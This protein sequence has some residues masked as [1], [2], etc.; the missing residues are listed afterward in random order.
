MNPVT[1][2]I[3][4]SL[5]RIRTML[6]VLAVLL[7]VFQFLLTQI[8]SYLIRRDAFSEI[9]LLMPDFVRSLLGP[10]SLAFL[11][12]SGIVAFGYFHPMV[13]AAVVWLVITIASEPAGEVETRFVDLA[14]ARELRRGDFI[15]RTIV[16]L[17]FASGF[18]LGLMM[19]GTW[20]GLACCVPAN[21]PHASARL[22]VSLAISLGAVMVCWSGVALAVAAAARR[23]SVA[24][25]IVGIAA[26]TAFL[27]DYVGRAWDPARRVSMISPF[28]YFDP[29]ALVAGQPLSAANIGVLVAIGVVGM[30]VAAIVFSRRDI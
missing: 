5:R 10:S 4:H 26:L 20:T 7:S 8:A 23:R 14:L 15:A 1:A 6:I 30:I 29:T 11:S 18:V 16:V 19:L 12:F 21:A 28:H 3:A 9:A 24:A 13:I 25:G 22:I 17:V 2:L 27:L